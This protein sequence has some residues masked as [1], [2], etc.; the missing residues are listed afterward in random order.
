M[1][2]NEKLT[3]T[4][5]A[6]QD[7]SIN[8]KRISKMEKQYISIQTERNHLYDV[9]LST[10]DKKTN[11]DDIVTINNRITELYL[12]LRKIKYNFMEMHH[13]YDDDGK[14]ETVSK[15]VQ[16]ENYSRDVELCLEPTIEK[17]FMKLIKDE[18]NII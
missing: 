14:K 13:L 18:N 8:E 11:I 17:Y 4:E 3:E 16:K 2:E 7:V 9:S 5:N 6:Y 10:I 15:L 12:E 1:E